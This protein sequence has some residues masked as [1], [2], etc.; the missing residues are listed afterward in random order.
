MCLTT[1][2]ADMFHRTLE[3]DRNINLAIEQYHWSMN[4]L[5][6]RS[7]PIQMI[8]KCYYSVEIQHN[9]SFL[10]DTS[11]NVDISITVLSAVH[12]LGIY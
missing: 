4:Q 7:G 3:D 5:N 6:E 1:N 12:V 9:N 11:T 10:L 2:T 8:R